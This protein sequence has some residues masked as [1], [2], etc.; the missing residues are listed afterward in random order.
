MKIYLEDKSSQPATTAAHPSMSGLV[1]RNNIMGTKWMSLYRQKDEIKC[2]ILHGCGKTIAL[3]LVENAQNND[4]K[5]F[6]IRSSVRKNS[7]SQTS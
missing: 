1:V 5:I 4:N 7:P 3:E 6:G 2:D